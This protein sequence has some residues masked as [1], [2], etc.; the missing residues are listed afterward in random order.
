MLRKLCYILPLLLA[1]CFTERAAAQ[2]Y[3]WGS[4]AASLRW[5][6]VRTHDVQ[7]IYPDTVAAVARRTLFYIDTVK[8]DIGYGFRHGPMR[9]PFVMHPENFQSNG[10][11]IWLPKRIEF[12]TSPSVE[13]YSMPWIKQ[14]VAHE[15]RH[16]VQYNNLNRGVVRV[17]S[18]FLGQQ[19]ST[20]GL[21]YLPIWTIE[22]DAVMSE[23]AMSSFGRGLQP[24]FTLE[25]RAM[26]DLSQARRNVDKWFCGSYRDMVPDHYQM[27]YQICSYTY[28]HFGKNIWDKVAWYSVRNPYWILPNTVA[29]KKFY[30]TSEK[31]LFCDTFHHLST[32][33][34]SLPTPKDSSEPLTTL[35][36]KNY[37]TYASPLPLDD[38][39]LLVVKSDYNRPSRFVRL[40]TR[41][42][43]EQTICYTGNISTR[44]D[45]GGSHVWWTEYRRSLL[46]EQRVNS[47]LC[48]MDLRDG[49]PRTYPATRNALYPVVMRDSLPAWVEYQPEGLYVVVLP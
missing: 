14:L 8:P 1:L 12:L 45:V 46:F 32:F 36:A 37:T 49:R 30:K 15:Y 33:W 5:N 48:Y 44:P 6:Q 7:L 39:T 35:P 43:A 26:D 23:T 29:L 4:D 34:S 2:Y 9:I 25:Y 42:G 31:Q 17:A 18:W 16:A 27:G 38:S 20:L 11:V 10:L 24:R 19:G 41:T 13:S 40:N 47:Q 3:T 21:I 22:G 28:D